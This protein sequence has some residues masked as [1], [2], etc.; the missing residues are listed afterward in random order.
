MYDDLVE[1]GIIFPKSLLGES[2]EEHFR[3]IQGSG[4]GGLVSILRAAPGCNR[5]VRN[6]YAELIEKR[7]KKIVLSAENLSK[8]RLAFAGPIARSILEGIPSRVIIYLRNPSDW[9]ES[10]YKEQVAGSHQRETRDIRQF[11]EQELAGEPNIGRLLDAWESDDVEV[12]LRNYEAARLPD[13]GLLQDFLYASGLNCIKVRKNLFSS[14]VNRSL[15]PKATQLVRVFDMLSIGTEGE[16]Y[17]IALQEYLRRLGEMLEND[18]GSLLSYAERYAIDQSWKGAHGDFSQRS[19]SNRK[20]IEE[21][22]V[23]KEKTVGT[24]QNI[25]ARG[26]DIAF[27]VCKTYGIIKLGPHPDIR[28]F[29]GS[30]LTRAQRRI[31]HDA[32]RMYDKIGLNFP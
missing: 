14:V 19:D 10:V 22:T 21:L 2:C 5:F 29:V 3:G 1:E 9:I 28:R 7:P 6:F 31:R 27:E 11:M 24:D 4:H 15:G 20:L 16:I 8:P 13:V 30:L 23:T 32:M 17:H 25:D 18:N 12:C 26:I